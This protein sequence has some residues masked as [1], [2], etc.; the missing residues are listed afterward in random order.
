ME[1]HSVRYVSPSFSSSGT[2][3]GLFT[4][5]EALR[6]VVSGFGKVSDAGTSQDAGSRK[7]WRSRNRMRQDAREFRSSSL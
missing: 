4:F 5:M 6:R 1:Q 7:N 2:F 3:S